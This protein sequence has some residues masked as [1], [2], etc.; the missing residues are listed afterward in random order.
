M[1]E[2]DTSWRRHAPGLILKDKDRS[3]EPA[4]AAPSEPETE[5]A[6]LVP[7]LRH[8]PSEAW[9][10][11]R[12]AARH[13]AVV[14]A[15]FVLIV[16]SIAALALTSGAGGTTSQ[17]PDR[18]MFVTDRMTSCRALPADHAEHV[19]YLVRSDAV[20]FVRREGDWAIISYGGEHCWVPLG[21]LAAEPI[22]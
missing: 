19:R 22:A 3:E 15:A 7:R 9:S 12:F 5:F 2:T 1:R 6:R 20:R 13:V 14:A 10:G 18:T 4:K 17:S 8:G 11:G 16:L 21:M